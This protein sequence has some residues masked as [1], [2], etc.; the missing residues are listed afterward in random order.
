MC[1]RTFRKNYRDTPVL[2]RIITGMK[3]QVY[4]YNNETKWQ[5]FPRKTPSSPHLKTTQVCSC[6]KCTLPI[7]FK[8]IEMS[9]MNSFHR[10]KLQTNTSVQMFCN[11]Y[12]NMGSENNLTSGALEISFSYMTTVLLTLLSICKNVLPVIV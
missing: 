3:H 1:A 5:Y 11:V 7:S 9:I 12:G 4:R 6:L 10:C 2:S 8:C